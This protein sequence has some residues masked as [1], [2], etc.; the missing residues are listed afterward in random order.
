VDVP[1]WAKHLPIRSSRS[2]ETKSR[3]ALELSSSSGMSS[4][5]EA[6][7]D[8][9]RLSESPKSDRSSQSDCG[10]APPPSSSSQWCSSSAKDPVDPTSSSP[11]RCCELSTVV[12]SNTNRCCSSVGV[13]GCCKLTP[14]AECPGGS[15][16]GTLNA[17][18][19]P[20]A[21]SAR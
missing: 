11:G 9:P 2:S 17:A 13:A 16:D 6:S 15:A 14:G 8:G 12:L 10:S 19:E 5:V 1:N 4:S 7:H 3:G 18:A 21:Y 20:N